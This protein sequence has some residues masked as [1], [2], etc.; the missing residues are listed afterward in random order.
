MMIGSRNTPIGRPL[1]IARILRSLSAVVILLVPL[2]IC[3]AENER[4]V[5]P[6]PTDTTSPEERLEA[7]GEVETRHGRRFEGRIIG[8]DAE[9][10]RLQITEG[11]GS[12][13]ITFSKE[14]VVSLRLTGNSDFA[15]FEERRAAGDNEGAFM[16]LRALYHQRAPL[17]HYLSDGDRAFFLDS[18]QQFRLGGDPLTAIALS[19]QLEPLV[20]AA[21][22]GRILARERILSY[23][24]LELMDEAKEEAEKWVSKQPI[25]LESTVG[26]YALARIHLTDGKS[27]EAL[28]HALTAVVFATDGADYLEHCYRLAIRIAESLGETSTTQKLRDE[29][30][31]RY[32]AS[33]T[34]VITPSP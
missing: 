15:A 34:S 4:A 28:E 7:R 12:A 30:E 6:E 32:P 29:M 20:D 17:L 24:Q 25:F 19:R 11:H 5:Q 13:E 23:L 31:R 16:L 8:A 9:T 27:E 3:A 1:P 10:L 22:A 33:P 14:D 21:S 26:H 2:K 18:L